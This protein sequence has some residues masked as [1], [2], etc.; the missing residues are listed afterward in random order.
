ML[1]AIIF[2]FDYTLGDSTNGIVMSINYA[3]EQLG[4]ST[5]S[6]EDIKKTIGLSLKE[7][8]FA[9]TTNNDLNK[10]DKFAD[11]FKE[12]ADEV[13]VDNT[14]LYVGVKDVL[15]RLKETGYAT[16]I[17]TTKYH[18]R[19]EQILSKYAANDLIDI[20]V[21]AEDVKVEKPNP[22]GLLW[23]INHLGIKKE[24]ALYIGDSLVD[25]QTA[26]NAGVEFAAV[27][28]GTTTRENFSGYKCMYVG[29]NIADVF[30]HI[31][32]LEDL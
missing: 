23:T 24:D 19:I 11:F 32:I 6:V 31:L 26:E 12:K 16:A 21:G 30:N 3:L 28:T 20:I 22:E 14:Q 25:A 5:R 27:L 2:D 13:M 1:K 17:V 4:C 18:Y 8:Y 15:I 7:T 29:E 10:A 9:L